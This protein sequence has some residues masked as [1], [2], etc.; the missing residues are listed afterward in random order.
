MSRVRRAGA[1]AFVLLA[2]AGPFLLSGPASAAP[3]PASAPEYWFDQWQVPSLWQQ[4][5]R[6]G[7]ITIAVVDTGVN[8][9]IPQL[10]GKLVTGTDFNSGGDGTVDRDDARLG[11]GTAMASIMVA[12]QGPFGIEGLAPDAKV[13]PIAINLDDTQYQGEGGDEVPEAIDWA[14]DHGAKI[15]NLSLGLSETPRNGQLTCEPDK[16]EAIFNALRKGV[17]VVA[18]SG[19]DGPDKNQLQTPAACLGVISVGAVDSTG[20]VASF[21]AR[22]PYLTVTAP[23]VDVASFGKQPGMAWSGDGTSQAAAL[24]SAALALVWSKFPALTA[25]QITSRLMA[26]LDSPHSPADPAYGYG[27]VDPYTAITSAVPANASNP[28]DEAA[29]PFLRREDALASPPAIP[30]P[31]LPAAATAPA[32]RPA[33]SGQA[34]LGDA[35]VQAG[36]K[37]A[38][39]GLFVL[40]L[41][42]GTG[43]S[44]YRRRHASTPAEPAPVSPPLLQPPGGEPLG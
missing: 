22:H 8:G 16:Q 19:N 9:A 36:A 17:I 15:V 37:L 2:V 41:V 35:R 27:R 26:T 5:A 11:H 4:G 40:V 1:A 38:A 34:W 14:V 31:K 32:H 13:M 10:A 23:G 42:G 39:A 21:S 30:K 12:S 20:T 44:G 6:G 43:L 33:R 28:V 25:E 3:G 7:G 18:A 24:T 29:E